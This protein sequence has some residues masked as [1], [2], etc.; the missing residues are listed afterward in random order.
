MILAVLKLFSNYSELNPLRFLWLV[1]REQAPRGL[2]KFLCPGVPAVSP[3]PSM[4]L[5][6]KN[7]IQA[8]GTAG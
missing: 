6:G 1:S 7:P 4:E 3:A 8:L 2:F 5:A